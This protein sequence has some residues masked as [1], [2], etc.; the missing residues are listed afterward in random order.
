VRDLTIPRRVAEGDFGGW[1]QEAM[2]DR[3][4][5]QRVLAMRSGTNHSTISRLIK[6]QRAPSL[7]TALAILRVL[8][9]APEQAPQP[10]EAATH[11]EGRRAA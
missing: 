3:R 10:V 6:G 1:L 4:M 2:A 11:S 5:S 8:L 9:P 7:P